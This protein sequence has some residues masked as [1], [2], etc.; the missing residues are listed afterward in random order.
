MSW[1]PPGYRPDH[2]TGYRVTFEDFLRLVPEPTIAPLLR[3]WFGQE[4]TSATANLR[5]IHERIQSDP[6]RQYT[7]YQRAMDIWR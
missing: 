4:I 2:G 7:L 6:E 3:D 1:P 5:E